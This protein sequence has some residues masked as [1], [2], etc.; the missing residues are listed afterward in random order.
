[1]I[2]DARRVLDLESVR[3]AA[4]PCGRGTR[5]PTSSLPSVAV[6]VVVDSWE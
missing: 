5:T 4:P 6:V 3:A 2:S 1:M